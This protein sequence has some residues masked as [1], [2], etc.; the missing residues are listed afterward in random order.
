M[1]EPEIPAIVRIGVLSQGE[2]DR[3]GP[4]LQAQFEATTLALI[5]EYGADAVASWRDRAHAELVF[6]WGIDLDTYP[7]GTFIHAGVTRLRPRKP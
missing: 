2:F 4:E 1:S 3:L 6:G 5:A 7:E